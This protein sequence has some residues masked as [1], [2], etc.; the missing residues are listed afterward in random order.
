MDKVSWGAG[1]LT[2]NTGLGPGTPNPPGR[3]NET[4]ISAPGT[5]ATK[6]Y[7]A[8]TNTKAITVEVWVRP[9]LDDI[10]GPARIVTYSHP[11]ESGGL[12]N[13]TLGPQNTLYAHRLRI[14]GLA[15]AVMPSG[16]G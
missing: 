5:P 6:L 15:M 16:V 14:R 4:I 7:D 13:F 10:G 11:V 9:E 3:F 2:I 8:V 12:R 1:F